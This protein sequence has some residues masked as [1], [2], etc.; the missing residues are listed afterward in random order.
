MIHLIKSD[1]RLRTSK[2]RRGGQTRSVDFQTRKLELTPG[3]MGDESAIN[4]HDRLFP[5]E[6]CRALST[7]VS[8]GLLALGV[9][10]RV[11]EVFHRGTF[12][13][14]MFDRVHMVRTGRFENFI[15]VFARLLRWMLEIVLGV[16]DILLV[17]AI[18]LLVIVVVAGS[19]C[20]LL[21]APLLPLL[22]PLVPFLAPL[23]M[24]LDGAPRPLL[25]TVYPSR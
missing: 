16:H 9:S 3:L 12:C 17:G 19:S 14:L 10:P 5:E 11:H 24:A 22:P 1:L 21:G 20:D 7:G 13:E 18:N 4:Q 6:G 8:F 2:V 25:E 15:K 23:P